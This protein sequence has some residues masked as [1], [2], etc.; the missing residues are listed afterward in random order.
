MR[1]LYRAVGR[2]QDHIDR[3]SRWEE[4]WPERL[5]DVQ[6]IADALRAGADAGWIADPLAQQ[7]AAQ[8]LAH[9]MGSF[10]SSTWRAE[11]TCGPTPR[12]LDLFLLVDHSNST[13]DSF[14]PFDEGPPYTLIRQVIADA[15]DAACNLVYTW[16][17]DLGLESRVS[18]TSFRTN[19]NSVVPVQT[20]W[21]HW[22]NWAISPPQVNWD[23]IFLSALPGYRSTIGR[24][25][26]PMFGGVSY[27]NFG[28]W[29][30]YVQWVQATRG[31]RTP[32]WILMSD[33][34]P[35][36]SDNLLLWSEQDVADVDMQ[37]PDGSW[38][39]SAEVRQLGAPY[40]PSSP[41]FKA[42][43]VLAAV[44]D[45]AQLA[46]NDGHELNSYY[47]KRAGGLFDRSQIMEWWADVGGG[48]HYVVEWGT[49]AI[50]DMLA[51]LESRLYA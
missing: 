43:S 14:T 39:T 44:M 11:E 4:C 13:N 47:I 22:A 27:N 31:D 12:P 3:V 46:L 10:Y 5:P 2:A 34:N 38:K 23:N 9:R 40:S 1:D 17:T 25:N 33:G 18:I 42:G 19:T 30:T 41:Q 50:P 21:H 32:V 45:K 24:G 20:H 37:N 15:L 16:Y 7:R 36:I 28:M 48:E 26:T 49:T 35:N 6:P 8:A 29:D 51:H